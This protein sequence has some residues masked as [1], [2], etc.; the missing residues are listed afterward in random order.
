[1]I[2][3][4]NRDGLRNKRLHRRINNRFQTGSTFGSVQLRVATYRERG[5]YRVVAE[6]NPRTFLEDEEYPTKTA[7]L[8][9]GFDVDSPPDY[10][11][12]WFN[13]VEPE[14]SLL[15]GWHQ[16]DD[17]PEYG[18]VHLQLNQSKSAVICKRV[19]F[20]GEHPME[21]VEARLELLPDVVQ[22][23][24]WERGSVTEVDW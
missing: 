18:E 10:D 11:F 15:L 13:W 9:I 12:Y 7:R 8:E 3:L 14:R 16:D 17:H 2:L 6:T 1:M 20:I 5:P 21:V 4:A 24:K 22:A 19:E 23:I